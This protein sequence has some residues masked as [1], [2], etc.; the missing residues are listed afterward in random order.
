[1]TPLASVINCY[2]HHH[3][4][5]YDSVYSRRT[6]PSTAFGVWLQR[7]HKT[8][9]CDNTAWHDGRDT[10]TRNSSTQSAGSSNNYGT[11]QACLSTNG[12]VD[13]PLM[14]IFTPHDVSWAF[15]FNH[16]LNTRKWPRYY[17][18][19]RNNIDLIQLHKSMLLLTSYA[20]HTLWQRTQ[21]VT[22]T[23]SLFLVSFS[24]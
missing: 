16:D 23:T 9:I 1:M 15:D 20:F 18:A 2:H 6:I 8:Q 19:K 21:D 10:T 5:M 24:K 17:E 7:Q 22:T 11:E 13:H 4:Q 12:V 3:H 14:C